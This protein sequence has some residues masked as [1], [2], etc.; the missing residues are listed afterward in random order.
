MLRNSDAMVE[1][2]TPES[3]SARKTFRLDTKEA[4]TADTSRSDFGM[5]DTIFGAQWERVGAAAVD[6]MLDT[7]GMRSSVF[8]ASTAVA[9][10]PASV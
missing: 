10:L 6:G 3:Q 5:A 7:V 2:K 9:S 1:N 8:R 4:R